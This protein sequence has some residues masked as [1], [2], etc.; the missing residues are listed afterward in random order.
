MDSD[1][2]LEEPNRQI[3]IRKP[4]DFFNKLVFLQA[5][6]IYNAMEFVIAPAYT[7]LSLFAESFQ[8]AEETKHTVESAVRKSPSVVAQRVKVAARRM[9]Y[10]AVAAGM[11]CMVMVLLLVVA[12]GVSGLG[13]RYWIEEPVDVKEKLK[14]D[15][16]E[17][18]PRA[19][20]GTGNGNTMKMKKKNLGIPVGHTFYVCV[21]LLMPE[22]QFNREFGVFQ[23]FHFISF[24]FKIYISMGLWACLKPRKSAFGGIIS[25]LTIYSF[26]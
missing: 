2:E 17:A 18:R 22:S 20:F 11:M 3:Q 4:T 23:V 25:K 14:F 6:L 9:S 1:Y 19:L 12:M 24:I 7:L 8:R 5:D 10:G 16:T 13:I 26:S 21:V 15:Y